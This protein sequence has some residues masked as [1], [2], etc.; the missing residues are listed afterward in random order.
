[1]KVLTYLIAVSS[2][3]LFACKSDTE[4]PKP[5]A[6]STQAQNIVSDKPKSKSNKDLPPPNVI[7][8]QR[9]QALAIIN[10]R[11]KKDPTIYNIVAD[12][13]WEYEFVHRG[14]MS[15]PGEYAGVWIN[16][17]DDHTYDYG[18]N[19]QVDGTGKYSYHFERSELLMVDDNSSKK[20]E[21]WSIK[22]QGSVMIM[23]G[24]ATYKDNHTQKKLQN[25]P[26][27]HKW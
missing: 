12:G 26:E 9:A 14:E 6:K 22:A 11:L 4:R 16:F 24:T 7:A 10:H 18:T 19:N 23:V 5:V 2:I 1:L 3:F 25:H 27:E 13:K 20:P 8:T 21:E 17:K 15:K